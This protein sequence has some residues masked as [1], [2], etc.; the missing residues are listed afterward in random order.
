MP[1]PATLLLTLATPIPRK[2]VSESVYDTLLEAIVTGRIPPGTP[3]NSVNLA[4][5]L[6]VSRT[7]VKEALRLLEHDGLIE[8]VN[9]HQARVVE[10]TR[11]DLVEIYEV[12]LHLEAASA[13]LAAL[14]LSDD[15][16]S[17]LKSELADL[18]LARKQPGWSERALDFDWKFHDLLAE[19]SGNSRLRTEI[20]RYRLLVRGFCRV[21]GSDAVL[22]N[23]VQEHEEI[24]HALDQRNPSLA[25]EC[26][27]RHIRS[28]LNRILE[29]LYPET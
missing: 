14:R 2:S 22:W 16:L 29:E 26:M 28:R 27:R 3:L 24:L 23:A 9:H 19:A 5:Q 4:T 13:E 12:R 10:L 1:Q 18:K 6:D 17:T 20:R 11:A 8:Q 21:V 15:L 25:S 7:P